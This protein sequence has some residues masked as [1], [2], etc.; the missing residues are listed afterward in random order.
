MLSEKWI[1]SAARCYST[2]P[3]SEL[4]IEY[5]HSEITPGPVGSNKARITRVIP[6][7][8]FGN[9]P[10]VNDIALVESDTPIVTGFH[11]PFAK[12]VIPGG[13]RFRSGTV[14]AHAGWGHIKLNV[15]TTALQKADLNILSH[16]ECVEATADTQKPEWNNICA[17]SSS[18]M[19]S[20]DLGGFIADQ[21]LAK[22]IK[23]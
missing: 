18:V 22:F 23:I 20:G 8:E 13:S 10:L 5:G 6:H 16:A 14:S 1:L 7:E 2:R 19:C 9:A 3:L 4:N 11:E 12:L 15:R 21:N 17:I